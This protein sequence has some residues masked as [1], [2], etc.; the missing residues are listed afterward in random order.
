M[1]KTL[2]SHAAAVLAYNFLCEI[3]SHCIGQTTK[4]TSVISR[5]AQSQHI[6]QMLAS[7]NRDGAHMGKRVVVLGVP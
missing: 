4:R 6:P 3:A 2:H 7:A 1:I 5:P